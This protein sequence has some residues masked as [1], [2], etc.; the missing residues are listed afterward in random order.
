MNDMTAKEQIF[1]KFITFLINQLDVIL[2]KGFKIIII[3]I[4]MFVIIKISNRAITKFVNRQISS[5]AKFSLE[6]QKAKTIGEVLKSA[7]KYLTYFIGITLILSDV[8]SGVSVALAG[9]GGV[10]VGFG[11]QSLVK[12]IINGIFVLF[13]DQYGVGDYITIDKYSGIVESIGIR[14]TVI[15]DFSGDVHLIPNGIISEVTN[16]SRGNIRFIIDVPI[17]YEEDIDKVI[18]C[19][20]DVCISFDK[21]NSDIVE[22]TKIM[23]VQELSSDGVVI[24]I[25]GRS[26]PLKQ[27]AM[28]NK[29]RKLIKLELDRQNIEIPYRKVQIV[30]LEADKNG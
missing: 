23:G 5:N 13:E 20:E 18:K 24:R 11:T 29:L 28:E 4:A 6:P 15:R 26:I 8:F 21:D 22:P 27:W 14:T 1:D 2:N 12:D 25:M 19:L 30:N 3:C 17:A 10:A 16:H 9:V 7:V